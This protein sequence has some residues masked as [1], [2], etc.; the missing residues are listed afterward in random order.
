VHRRVQSPLR[1]PDEKACEG[2]GSMPGFARPNDAASR[3]LQSIATP[4]FWTSWA[5][6]RPR[7][8][9]GAGHCGGVSIVTCSTLRSRP[10][11]RL[12]LGLC[13]LAQSAVQHEVAAPS[14]SLRCACR[15]VATPRLSISSELWPPMRRAAAAWIPGESPRCG[16]RSNRPAT[17]APALECGLEKCGDVLPPSSN[18]PYGRDPSGG[19]DCRATRCASRSRSPRPPLTPAHRQVALESVSLECDRYGATRGKVV[20]KHD[21]TAVRATMSAA[22]EC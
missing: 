21:R 15:A 8:R 20:G 3:D 9:Y 22:R 7:R 17:R 6:E 16:R 2:N 1:R 13:D 10:D 11:T 12:G 18:Q 19:S 4:W 14:P 5:P